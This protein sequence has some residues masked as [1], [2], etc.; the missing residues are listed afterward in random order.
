MQPTAL[1]VGNADKEWKSPEGRKRNYFR[2]NVA[3]PSSPGSAERISRFTLL[4]P[5]R[6]FVLGCVAA[7]RLAPWAAFF[8]RP[9]AR[10]H[11]APTFLKN[12]LSD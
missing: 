4:S 1:A 6:G 9:A 2:Q 7:P 10:G 11:S 8:R 5:L 3:R 12:P